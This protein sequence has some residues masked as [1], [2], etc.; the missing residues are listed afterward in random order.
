V[1]IT[2][3]IDNWHHYSDILAGSIIGAIAAC[4]AYGYN[5]GSIFCSK[6]AGLP[7][8]AVH[9]KMKSESVGDGLQEVHEKMIG[10]NARASSDRV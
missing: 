4:L 7:F 6:N 1:A 5:Y 3:S 8:E 9:E 2:R 10:M